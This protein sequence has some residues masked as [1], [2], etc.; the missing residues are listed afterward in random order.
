MEIMAVV[1]ADA[2]GHGDIIVAKFLSDYG[3]R[4]FAVSNIDKAIH[5][6]NAGAVG[7]ILFLGY[8]PVERTIDL[9][10][11]DVTQA[12]LSEEDAEVIKRTG[13]PKNVSSQ[14]ILV[15]DV[16]GNVRYYQVSTDEVYGD[17][18][19]DR[20]DLFFTEETPIQT[21]SPYSSS[22]AGADLLELAYL[23]THGLPQPLQQQLRPVS[24]P[25]KADSTHDRKLPE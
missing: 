25:R 16:F 4:H 17:V 14:L 21:S 24:F 2:Y 1:K 11:Y 19:L 20:P 15:C 7:Q 8:T 9:V 13:L 22:K 18:P 23:R 3:V 5:I 12:L 10:D 6:R